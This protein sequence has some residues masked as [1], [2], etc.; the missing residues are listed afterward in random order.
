M[1]D[2]TDK[3]D[4]ELPPPATIREAEKMIEDGVPPEVICK[5]LNISPDQL[6]FLGQR[7]FAAF[8]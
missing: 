7:G 2:Y 6:Q 5:V 1:F 3:P 4:F 8:K